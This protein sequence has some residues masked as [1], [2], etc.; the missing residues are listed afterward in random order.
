MPNE[1]LPWM[2][3]PRQQRSRDTFHR[4]LDGAEELLRANAFEDLTVKAIVKEARSSVGSFYARFPDKEGLLK[5]LYERRQQ[6][7]TATIEKAWDSEAW[8]DRSIEEIIRAHVDFL[9]R[10]YAEN[11]GLYRALVLRGFAQPDWRY[12]SAQERDKLSVA[13]AGR[14]F[15]SRAHEIAHENPRLAGSLGYLMVIATLR[16]KILF[17][18]STSSGLQISEDHLAEELTRAFLAYLG[19]EHGKVTKES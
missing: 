12:A 3:A 9:I 6:E 18:E 8:A 11:R 14:L 19:I 1:N 16:E 10:L 17:S 2:K 15:E 7:A 13:S 4:F 5:A